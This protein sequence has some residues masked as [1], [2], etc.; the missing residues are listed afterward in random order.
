MMV[1]MSKKKLL[2]THG[3]LF[4]FVVQPFRP[5][6]MFTSKARAYP[7]GATSDDQNNILV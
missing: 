5:S 7:C 4:V 1:L 2:L 6:D 3:Q